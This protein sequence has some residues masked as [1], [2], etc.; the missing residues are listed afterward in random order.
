MDTQAA[1][2]AEMEAKIRNQM[3]SSGSI[4]TATAMML[5]TVPAN[6]VP[7]ETIWLSGVFMPLAPIAALRGLQT[8][9]R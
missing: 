7:C 9:R 3:S 8:T 5:K 6:P 2:I 1:V 4:E